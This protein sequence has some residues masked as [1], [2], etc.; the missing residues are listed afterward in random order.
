MNPLTHPLLPKAIVRRVKEGR[1][2]RKEAKKHWET[3]CGYQRAAKR[4][5]AALA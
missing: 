2:L 1:W 3:H 4:K 5:S